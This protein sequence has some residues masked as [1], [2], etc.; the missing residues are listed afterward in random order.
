MK[1][2]FSS[3]DVSFNSLAHNVNAV[4]LGTAGCPVSSTQDATIAPGEDATFSYASSSYFQTDSDPTPTISG[5][6][7]AVS[8]THLTLPTKRIV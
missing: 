1:F 8:Y 5:T 2:Q 3:G 4:D 7:G 6:T